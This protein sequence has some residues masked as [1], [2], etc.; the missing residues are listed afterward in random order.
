MLIIYRYQIPWDEWD[1]SILQPD[2]VDATIPSH[3]VFYRTHDEMRVFFWQR[4][5]LSSFMYCLIGN[6]AQ[7]TIWLQFFW[8]SMQNPWHL[9]AVVGLILSEY[10][11]VSL[12][13]SPM[14]SP[15]Q[16]AGPSMDGIDDATKKRR[17]DRQR[18]YDSEFSIFNSD[19]STSPRCTMIVIRSVSQLCVAWPSKT[20]VSWMFWISVIWLCLI[21]HSFY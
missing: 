1:P 17:V 19:V 11:P 9:S 6:I 7:L 15:E 18:K 8:T 16:Y 20:H 2:L 13:R 21:S 10:A 12:Q 14:R 4:G 5:G 3:F